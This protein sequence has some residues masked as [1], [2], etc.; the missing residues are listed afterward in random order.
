MRIAFVGALLAAACAVMC[1]CPLSGAT[2]T[3]MADEPLVAGNVLGEEEE[4]MPDLAGKTLEELN[5]QV[6]VL[7]A[8]YDEL[9]SL[10][11]GYIARACENG[12]RLASAERRLASVEAQAERAV[13]ERYKLQRH[14]APL[15]DS[16]LHA[17]SLSAFISQLSYIE[18]IARVDV[19]TVSRMR[20]SNVRYERLASW[21]QNKVSVLEERIARASANLEE[22]VKARDE[23]Q[24]L[25]DLVAE[26]KLKPDEADW[27][28]GEKAFI[29]T[30][31]P[32]IDAYLKDSP[33]EGLGKEFAKAAWANHVDPRFSPA[34]ATIESGKG[35]V[36]IR[37]HNAWGW[38]AADSDPY[39]L[40]SE[41][42][43]WEQAINTHLSG[44]AKWYG[45]T[46][47]T[48]GAQMYCPLT[49]ESW[50]IGVVKEM[51]RIWP[52]E[53]EEADPQP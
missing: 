9:C 6:D 26:T 39:G 44:L 53:S 15:I 21:L 20:E 38:G 37:P 46:V 49:W 1:L 29:A 30:W 27:D 32:R 16:L 33:M 8:R 18:I 25:A 7:T 52:A 13:V 42:D 11:A 47:T 51:N 31:A 28:A 14:G 45:Y 2:A 12:M 4:A 34:I 36:C 50:Y 17:E 24:R 35:R 48:E 19:D 43:T 22:A 40:A 3:A 41:W 10:R 23:K 5:E